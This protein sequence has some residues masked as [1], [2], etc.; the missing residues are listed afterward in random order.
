[1]QEHQQVVLMSD[2]GEHVRRVQENLQPHSEHWIDW[3]PISMRVTVLQQQTKALPEERPETGAD[4]SKG[5]D[6][7][8]R[9]LWHANTEEAL[10]RLADLIMD[11]SLIQGRSAAAKKVAS[12]FDRV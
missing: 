3:F 9:L 11:L 2:G 10:E 7:V 12:R 1:M 8:K 5:L 6:R 4:V